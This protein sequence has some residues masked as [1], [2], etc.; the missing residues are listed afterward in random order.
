MRAAG[1]HHFPSSA[2]GWCKGLPLKPSNRVSTP[3]LRCTRQY[4]SLINIRS[5]RVLPCAIPG[6]SASQANHTPN[7]HARLGFKFSLQGTPLKETISSTCALRRHACSAVRCAASQQDAGA[8]PWHPRVEAGQQTGSHDP[9]QLAHVL[10]NFDVSCPCAVAH[11]T[12]GPVPGVSAADTAD[13][14]QLLQTRTTGHH[15][16]QHSPTRHQFISKEAALHP[17]VAVLFLCQR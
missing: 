1:L 2:T 4:H 9:L 3:L 11:A 12:P 7:Q 5:Q 8:A 16:K 6:Y 17:T 15:T 13:T 10:T 14:R